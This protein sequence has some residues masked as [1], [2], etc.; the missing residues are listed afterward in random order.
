MTSPLF[1]TLSI[2]LVHFWESKE[3]D[4][5]SYQSINIQTSDPI[6]NI[7]TGSC[8]VKTN[9]NHMNSPTNLANLLTFDGMSFEGLEI[10]QDDEA[11]QLLLMVMLGPHAL[12][13]VYEKF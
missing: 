11:H 3:N 1:E 4:W 7:F 8:P 6:H 9:D 12:D 10:S 5:S 13:E 2:D